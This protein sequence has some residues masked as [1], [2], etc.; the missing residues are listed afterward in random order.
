MGILVLQSLQAPAD[1]AMSTGAGKWGYD[2]ASKR[3]GPGRVASEG[4]GRSVLM[5]CHP[6]GGLCHGTCAD[7]FGNIQV[8][9]HYQKAEH[10]AQSIIN[11]ERGVKIS[12]DCRRDSRCRVQA[13][14]A[15]LVSV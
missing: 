8:C 11:V 9:K 10:L 12:T 3:G 7:G 1:R 13:L 6:G 2:R 5:V 14:S 4:R 15:M